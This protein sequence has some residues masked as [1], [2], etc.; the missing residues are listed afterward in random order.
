MWSFTRN[1]IYY[2]ATLFSSL[3]FFVYCIGTVRILSLHYMKEETIRENMNQKK[4]KIQNLH[5]VSALFFHTKSITT[6]YVIIQP[7]KCVILK[8]T[9]FQPIEISQNVSLPQSEF[10]KNVETNVKYNLMEET[11]GE[12]WNHIP[13]KYFSALECTESMT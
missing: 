2:K 11:Y 1:T 5:D 13:E 6:V 10:K 3:L 9:T 8:Q 7:K 12:N 4:Y